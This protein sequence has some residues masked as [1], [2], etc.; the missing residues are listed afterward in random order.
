MITLV[1]ASGRSMSSAVQIGLSGRP[2]RRFR[3]ASQMGQRPVRIVAVVSHRGG[4]GVVSGHF[5]SG[6]SRKPR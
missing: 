6:I 3:I 4:V 5:P 2:S 1:A